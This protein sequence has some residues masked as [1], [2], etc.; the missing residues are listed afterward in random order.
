MLNAIEKISG[1]TLRTNR[2]PRA[3]RFRFGVRE[4][5]FAFLCSV[6]VIFA[7]YLSCASRTAVE[8]TVT[9]GHAAPN[10]TSTPII[11]PPQ[12]PP[13]D[14]NIEAAG[15]RVAEAITLLDTTVNKKRANNSQTITRAQRAISQAG[16][17][18]TRALR[19]PSRNQ[20]LDAPL[21]DALKNLN[22]IE[23]NIARGSY[24]DAIRD[25]KSLD[26]KLD[27]L[28][29]QIPTPTPTPSDTAPSSTEQTQTSPTTQG[30]SS[31]QT[32]PANR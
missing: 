1:H 4:L 11:I 26:K 28:A 30:N 23:R 20:H 24:D 14:A 25:L 19:N 32:T 18:I 17:S 16:V 7:G 5:T 27:D 29:V 13:H 8:E 10:S 22:T 21:Q 31:Q 12:L 6:L 9:T 2:R 3:F 15:D